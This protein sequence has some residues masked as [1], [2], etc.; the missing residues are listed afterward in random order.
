MGTPRRK[1]TA[2]EAA[3]RQLVLDSYGRLSRVPE[4]GEIEKIET[5]WA[6]NRKVI[7][8]V[9]AVLGEELK[10]GLTACRRGSAPCAVRGGN[11]CWSGGVRGVGRDRG[12]A[13]R[14][15]VSS[16]A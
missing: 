5:Q 14:P 7:D 15:P 1:V 9:G 12:L 8:R 6:D 11:D 13:H 10:D 16:A 4:T 3:D 2:G